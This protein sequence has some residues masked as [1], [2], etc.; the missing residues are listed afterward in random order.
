M[1]AKREDTTTSDDVRVNERN[2]MKRARLLDAFHDGRAL[3]DSPRANDD[4]TTAVF[5]ARVV[6]LKSTF[7][8]GRGLKSTRFGRGPSPHP[9]AMD[10]CVSHA[11]HW[12][13]YSF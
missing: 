1:R 5:I 8:Y 6:G 7:R 10:T 13:T 2:E 9:T 4:A 11:P 3:T 12:S